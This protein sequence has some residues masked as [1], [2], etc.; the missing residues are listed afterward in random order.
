MPHLE[1]EALRIYTEDRND[2]CF[3]GRCF[4]LIVRDGDFYVSNASV[5]VDLATNRIL[6]ER[7]P[8]MKRI[9]FGVRCSCVLLANTGRLAQCSAPYFVEQAFPTGGPEETRWK[10][11]WQNQGKHGLVITAAF[12]RKSPSLARFS[13]CSGTRGW[14]RFSSPTIRALRDF[15][16]CPPTARGW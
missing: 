11:C 9:L 8:K 13:A 14:A 10:I 2:P 3:S 6:S 7:S 12:F 4:Y 16:I 15:S 1:P 5:T